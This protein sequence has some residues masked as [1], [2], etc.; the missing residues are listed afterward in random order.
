MNQLEKIEKIR[1]K[2]GLTYSEA[3]A[4]LDEAGG[5]VLDALLLLER[6]GRIPT[7]EVP[8]FSTKADTSEELKKASETYENT[9]GKSFGDYLKSFF[10][11]LGRLIKK[12]CESSFIVT[13]DGSEFFSMPV[14]VLVLLLVFAFWIVL[15]LMVVGLFF[16]FRY[17]FD[18]A[19]TKS[20]DVNTVCDKAAEAA[21]SVKNEFSSKK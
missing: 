19:I 5:D 14:I 18:G 12:G 15:P 20:I 10:A 4:A 17:H 7:P 6:Q 9:G 2:T 21:E 13:K 16:R 8:N 3:K 1:E 11:W